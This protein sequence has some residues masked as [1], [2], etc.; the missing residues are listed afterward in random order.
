MI[1]GRRSALILLTLSLGLLACSSTGSP[2]AGSPGATTLPGGGGGAT[3]APG[4]GGVPTLP[5]AGGGGGTIPCDKLASSVAS[6]SGLMI[7]K[8]DTQTTGCEFNLNAPGDSSDTGFVGIVSI[9]MEGTQP[10]QWDAVVKLLIPDANGVDVP[11]VGD[12]ARV[13]TDGS[14]M[15]AQHNGHIWAVQ[16]EIFG[17]AGEPDVKAGSILLMQ[18][19]FQL[20]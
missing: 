15:Y 16:Q 5:P 18:A 7:V 1:A 9:R 17:T 13:T 8:T 14:L 6:V 10:A 11:G 20:V 3:Q 12:R 2:G 19:L 4:G